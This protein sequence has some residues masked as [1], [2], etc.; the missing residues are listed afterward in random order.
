MSRVCS[1]R[2]WTV[3]LTWCV[4]PLRHVNTTLNLCS[5]LTSV[6][7][8]VPSSSA[9]HCR[10]PSES[11]PHYSH[12]SL[13]SAHTSTRSYS[14]G[15]FVA[16]LHVLRGS[17]LLSRSFRK[18]RRGRRTTSRASPSHRRSVLS[19]S[20]HTGPS[21]DGSPASRE[22]PVELL[23]FGA[24]LEETASCT[25]SALCSGCG[26]LRWSARRCVCRSRKSGAGAGLGG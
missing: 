21:R 2:S 3:L 12:L 5:H 4:D 1:D 7:N 10:S 16:A 18:T 23:L 17:T 8:D 20:C 24:S 9:P 14:P 6:M 22:S 15:S 26:R 11:H 13:A 25:R 19:L